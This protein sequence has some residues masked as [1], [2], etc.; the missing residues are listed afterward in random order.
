MGV[1]VH[2]SNSTTPPEQRLSQVYHKYVQ[3]YQ[4]FSCDFEN[5]LISR[6]KQKDAPDIQTSTWACSH[7]TVCA[8]WISQLLYLTQWYHSLE[9]DEWVSHGFLT[10]DKRRQRSGLS[11]QFPF[12][13]STCEVSFDLRGIKE[14]R[15]DSKREA[16]FGF[17]LKLRSIE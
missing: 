7:H 4:G 1:K 14:F 3:T 2:S 6:P 11:F 16:L 9:I 10:R 15:T 12:Y 13:H 17:S 8:I 5:Y